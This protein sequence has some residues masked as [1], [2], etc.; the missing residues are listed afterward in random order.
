MRNWLIHGCREVELEVVEKAVTQDVP[1]LVAH[2]ERPL[3]R[4]VRVAASQ[5][6]N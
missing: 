4:D 6:H 2:L 5:C 3:K 1:S